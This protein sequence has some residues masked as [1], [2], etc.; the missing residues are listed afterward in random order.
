MLNYVLLFKSEEEDTEE[1]REVIKTEE[2]MKIS[3]I[4]LWFITLC[5]GTM[6]TVESG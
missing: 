1:D 3:Q 5:R 2:R 4:I 6:E